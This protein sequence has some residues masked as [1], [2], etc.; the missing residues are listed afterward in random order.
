[1]SWS[2][3]R[4]WIALLKRK[5]TKTELRKMAGINT[6][7]LAQMGKDKPVTLEALGKI[8]TALDCQ[9]EDIVEFVPNERHNE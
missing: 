2:Y 8:C 6:Y 5:M 4:L 1:M 3:E 7:T 9:L